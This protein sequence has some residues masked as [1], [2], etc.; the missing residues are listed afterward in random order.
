MT[1]SPA[2]ASFDED[3]HGAIRVGLKADWVLWDRYIMRV[4]VNE[5]L[6]AKVRATVLDGEI[7]YGEM[8]LCG[9]WAIGCRGY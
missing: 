3:V 2:Y 9:Q 7:E 4:R 1:T 8:Y 5:I 6:Q